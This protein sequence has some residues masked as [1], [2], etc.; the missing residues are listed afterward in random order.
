MLLL[1]PPSIAKR[2]VLT[3]TAI[4]SKIVVLPAPFLPTINVICLSKSSAAVLK[5]L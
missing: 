3:E 2:N 1:T 5:H 4:A